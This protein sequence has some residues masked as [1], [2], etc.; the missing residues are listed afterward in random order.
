MYKA[1]LEKYGQSKEVYAKIKEYPL[2]RVYE[3]R[4]R[5][6]TLR[7]CK[8]QEIK[9]YE[10]LLFYI[11]NTLYTLVRQAAIAAKNALKDEEQSRQRTLPKQY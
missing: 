9:A 2:F 5:E 3:W 11:D 6:T 8:S 7:I 4:D 10:G 1:L